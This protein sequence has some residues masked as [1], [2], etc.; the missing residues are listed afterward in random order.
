MRSYFLIL[1]KNTNINY[2]TH[3]LCDVVFYFAFGIIRGNGLLS[4]CLL[5]LSLSISRAM[6]DDLRYKNANIYSHRYI[7]KA[8]HGR[9]LFSF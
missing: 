2:R 5:G 6:L 3:F 4:Y 8:F 1:S 7:P 9:V